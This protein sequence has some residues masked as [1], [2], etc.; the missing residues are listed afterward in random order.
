VQPESKSQLLDRFR[1]SIAETVAVCIMPLRIEAARHDKSALTRIGRTQKCPDDSI[2]NSNGSASGDAIATKIRESL[3]GVD[4][5]NSL[6]GP[7][8]QAID[9]LLAVA[10]EAVGSADASVLVRMDGREV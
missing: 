9:D 5:S 8:R 3:G 1:T 6:S 2:V 10:Q 4:L 7:I